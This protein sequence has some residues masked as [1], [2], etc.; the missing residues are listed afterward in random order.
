[1]SREKD[2]N[3]LLPL[4]SASWQVPVD[5][6]IFSSHF[7]S[8]FSQF[9]FVI[10]IFFFPQGFLSRTSLLNSFPSFLSVSLVHYIL[11]LLLSRFVRLKCFKFD[12]TFGYLNIFLSQRITNISNM[13][14]VALLRA[15]DRKRVRVRKSCVI[16]TTELILE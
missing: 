7:P 9:L 1:M 6:R 3:E 13:C 12:V 16:R 4:L 14:S 5:P 8:F 10:I 15:R 11:L 2:S